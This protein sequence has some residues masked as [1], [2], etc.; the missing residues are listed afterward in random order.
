MDYDGTLAYIH[1]IYRRGKKD[2]L[3]RITELLER[4]GNPQ[5]ALKI[6]HVAGTNGKGS[7]CS[8]LAGMLTEAGYKTGLFTSPYIERFNERIRI[9]GS[10]ISDAALADITAYVREFAERMEILPSE[11]ELVTAIALAYYR[12]EGCEAV[13]L[14]TGLGG[15]FDATNAVASPVLEII[16]PIDYDHKKELGDTLA[17]IAAHK[18]G[19]LKPNSVCVTCTQPPEAAEVIAAR[20]RALSIPEIVVDAAKLEPLEADLTGQRFRF[21]GRAYF[22]SLA[23]EYQPLNASIAI[24]AARALAARGFARLDEAAVRRA[25]ARARWIGRFELLAT[26]PTFVVDGGHN[27][28]GVGAA[29]RSAMKLLAGKRITVLLGV[30]ADKDFSHMFELIDTIAVRYVATAPDYPRAMPCDE[31][32]R[33][34][35]R[36]GKQ[37]E[38]ARTID[39]AVKVATELALNDDNGAVLALGT[40]YMVGDVRR[41]V[42]KQIGEEK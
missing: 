30:M 42:R 26:N 18:A 17:E 4:L 14:E 36:L 23:G 15:L 1:G 33:Q 3:K 40:L 6:V 35:S 37:V 34:L 20:C 31:L 10:E 24:A 5:N 2:G 21:D 9:D 8:M 19:I 22:V 29:V 13:V 28:Q 27:P 12:Q 11:F 39:D 16:T 41:A 32:A 38:T 25:L 7:V